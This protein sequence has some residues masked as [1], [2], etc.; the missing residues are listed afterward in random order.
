V[1][2]VPLLITCPKCGTLTQKLVA[3]RTVRMLPSD[4]QDS[5]QVATY[6]CPCGTAVTHTISPPILQELPPTSGEP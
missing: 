3:V 4:T 6:V 2:Y 1:D 5:G